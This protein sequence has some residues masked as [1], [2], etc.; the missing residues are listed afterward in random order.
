MVIDF[1]QQ[2]YSKD[3]LLACSI[4]LNIGFIVGLLL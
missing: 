2:K 4:G 3:F 1:V